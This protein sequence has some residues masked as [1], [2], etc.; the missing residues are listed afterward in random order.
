MRRIITLPAAAITFGAILL[1]PVSASA[2][3]K[4]PDQPK[5]LHLVAVTKTSI[6]AA[7]KPAAHAKRYRLY[8]GRKQR[9]LAVVRAASAA[10]AAK[11]SRKPRITVTGLPYA[12]APYYFRIAAINGSKR[13]FS[14]TIGSAELMP[15]SPTKLVAHSS[16]T[17]TYLTWHGEQVPHLT[18]LQATNP[19]FTAGRRT[20]QIRAIARQFTPYGLA[21]GQTYYFRVRSHSGPSHGK[22]SNVAHTTV[23]S[24]EQSLR[25]MT[26]N[27]MDLSRDGTKEDGTT[28]APW[29]ERLKGVVQWFRQASPDVAAVEEGGDWVGATGGPRQ[30]DS[31]VSALGGSYSLAHTEVSPGEPGCCHRTGQYLL[32]KTSAYRAVGDGGH[33]TFPGNGSTH[34]AAYQILQNRT[35]GARLL[36]VAVHVAVGNHKS[37]DRLRKRQ[38]ALLIQDARG[39]AAAHGNLPVVY[40]GDFNSA[41]Q[42]HAVDGPG[43]EMRKADVADAFNVAQSH[44]NSRFNS[45]NGY[46]RKPPAAGIYLDHI[47]ASP[48]VAVKSWR[49]MLNLQHGRFVG[50]IPSDHNPLVSDLVISY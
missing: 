7:V 16:A 9:D 24:S 8:V 41:P 47:F 46:F 50:V 43:I 42:N 31:V 11:S 25:M 40:G 12:T 19:T 37:A 38:T 5:H 36:V 10:V 45:A 39:Y 28:I 44:K 23:V 17:G 3:A 35:T 13:R 15:P 21:R 14:A 1:A 20:Y 48:G 27:L 34:E 29:S 49:L 18:V 4:T 30:V 33:W 2:S 32:Y 22:W 26:Y 6:T